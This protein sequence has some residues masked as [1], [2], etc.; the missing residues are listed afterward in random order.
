[1]K[2][3]L[4]FLPSL[5]VGGAERVTLTLINSLVNRYE[6]YLFLL[7]GRGELTKAVPPQ[8]N[9]IVFNSR[10]K[11]YP[12]IS[13]ISTVLSIRPD[14]ILL[15]MWP[16]T[17]IFGILSKL[18]YS[19]A[20]VLAVEHTSLSAQYQDK[21]ILFK[22]FLRFSLA[23]SCRLVDTTAGVSS[24]VAK[25]IAKVAYIPSHLIRTIHN[26]VDPP[27]PVS[28][29][30]SIYALSHWSPR[31]VVKLLFVGQLKQPKCISNIL[32]ALNKLPDDFHLLIVG[33]GR[34]FRTLLQLVHKLNL[35]SRVVFAG[36]H[37]D[38]AKFYK[39]ADMLVLASE[40][41]G[42]P[43]VMIEA[44]S[45]GLPIVS[46]DCNYGPSEILNNEHLGILVPVND[47]DSLVQG[48]LQA[49]N[50][51]YDVKL[52]HDRYLDFHPQLI[53]QQ[54]ISALGVEKD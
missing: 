41:E 46:T 20:T 31:A 13:F 38:L 35:S 44:L 24:G 16:Y 6:L 21:N 7:D 50:A 37:E 36:Y 4:L 14:A 42:L 53:T 9:I 11:K 34:E 1:M 2:K 10:F 45:Y 48:I 51:R 49:S 39:N 40:R 47:V 3:I 32:H 25:D 27:S 22:L 18:F 28:Q 30:D 8:C 54:Y 12:I 17:S 52:L 33:E 5:H 23:L 43:T 19:S 26:P 15:A 29:A